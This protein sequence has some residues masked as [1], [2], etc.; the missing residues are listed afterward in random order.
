MI[1][2][3]GYVQQGRVE[4]IVQASFHLPFTHAVSNF[5]LHA[6]TSFANV[7]A[8]LVNPVALRYYELPLEYWLHPGDGLF[9]W[10]TG[11]AVSEFC[12]VYLCLETYDE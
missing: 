10:S 8:E 7:L 9:V 4:R 2:L 11:W 5:Q 1:P 3:A 6:D 12:E